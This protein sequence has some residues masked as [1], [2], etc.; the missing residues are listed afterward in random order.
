M[1]LQKSR[2][3]EKQLVEWRREFHRIPELGFELDKT[4]SHLED[5]LREMGLKPERLAGTGVV[6]D[7]KAADPRGP[8]IGL[9]ADMDAMPV[10]EE[11]GLPFAS[12]HPGAMHACGHDA[13]MAMLLGAAKVL[14]EN[15]DAWKGRVRLI[16]Q[17]AEELVS[18]ARKMISE[19][20]LENPRVDAVFGLHIWQVMELGKIGL[21][22]GEFMASADNF[23][24]TIKGK[25]AHGA[26]PHE[27]RDS[28]AAAADLIQGLQASLT[29]IV[30]TTESYVLTFG[31]INGGTKGNI[32]AEKVEIDGTFRA[33]SP[34]V[35]EIINNRFADYLASIEKGHGVKADYRLLNSAPP[36]IND[37]NLVG[38]LEKGLVELFGR[39]EIINFGPVLPSEDFAEFCRKVPSVF[40]FLGAGG[41]NYSFPHHHSRFDI[42]ERALPLGTA[43]LL[44]AVDLGSELEG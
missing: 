3:M 31:K 8:V 17:P 15:S 38:K 14:I 42:D 7:I 33:F 18:G 23:S 40:F 21:K 41:D 29:R 28:V 12:E 10:E 35:R 20:V 16:F 6:A 4:A 1:W 2:E 32:V 26:M 39:E 22:P 24:V 25:A 13:H 37:Q 34:Q 5:I 43:A 9:R 11:T 44:K 36:L 19:G 27:G 30:P